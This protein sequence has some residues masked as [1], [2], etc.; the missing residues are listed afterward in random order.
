MDFKG[1]QRRLSK[2]MYRARVA[3]QEKNM[4]YRKAAQR[5][6]LP[7]STLSDAVQRHVSGKCAS[8]A[9]RRP[10]FTEPEGGANSRTIAMLLRPRR[11]ANARAPRRCDSALCQAAAGCSTTIDSVSRGS[12]GRE[13]CR[14]F[15]RRHRKTLKFV[16][17][18]KQEGKRFAAINARTIAAHFAVLEALISS[19]A[20]SSSRK[21]RYMRR[22]GAHDIKLPDFICSGR[23][24]LM[25][26][27]SAA[28]SSGPPLFVFTGSHLPYRQVVVNGQ[29][30]TQT[31]AAYLPRGAC[32]A[33]RA[34]TVLLTLDGYAA[35]MSHTVMELF[36]ANNIVVHAIPA[37]T[38]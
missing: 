7:K 30:S 37:H 11:S 17:P 19:D 14:A 32:L 35:H 18:T 16:V 33:V 38:S 20:R 2:R 24:T 3:V 10:V 23:T 25:P 28:G 31:Y 27:V 12:T 8:K 5:Y 6:H 4:S 22:T 26:V 34:K 9:S 1:A 36:K 21:R 13:V 15:L 29:I